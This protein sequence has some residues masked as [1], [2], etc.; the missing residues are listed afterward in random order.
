MKNIF[1]AFF[2]TTRN[3]RIGFICIAMI[4]VGILCYEAFKPT[5]H[6]DADVIQ[7]AKELQSEINS[8]KVDTVK[9]TR[10]RKVKADSKEKDTPTPTIAD[11]EETGTFE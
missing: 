7:M 2:S 9:K 8:S 1:K 11:F 10:K 6:I 4:M 5:P 3:E